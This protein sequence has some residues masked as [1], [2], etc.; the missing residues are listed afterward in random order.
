LLAQFDLFV[1]PSLWEGLPNA[2]IEAM[3]ARRAVV[4]TRV[5]GTPELVVD[6][7]TAT[8][9]EPTALLA[10][11]K[12]AGALA[13]AMER[14]LDD[15]ELRRRLGEAGRGRIETAFTMEGMV[16]EMQSLYDTLLTGCGK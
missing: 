2:V 14:I 4:A 11:P 12:D 15:E 1:L 16:E 7:A 13:E 10:P 9:E 5:D 8:A 6:G 3:A